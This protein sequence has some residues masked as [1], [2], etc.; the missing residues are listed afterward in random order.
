[1]FPKINKVEGYWFDSET[2]AASFQL[3]KCVLAKMISSR[4]TL[5]P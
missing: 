5:S 2:Y 3:D 4:K 1:M